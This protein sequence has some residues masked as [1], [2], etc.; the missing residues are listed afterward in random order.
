MLKEA[1]ALAPGPAERAKLRDE[2]VA[3]LALRDVGEPRAI[4]IDERER[5]EI[6]LDRLERPADKR[7]RRPAPRPALSAD[8]DTVR[9]F[10]VAKRQAQS[11][12]FRWP[13]PTSAPA[14]PPPGRPEA[15]TPK[16]GKR[17]WPR[18]PIRPPDRLGRAERRG[19]PARPPRGQPARRLDRG[20]RRGGRP[21]PLRP[22][23]RAPARDRRPGRL[24]RRRAARHRRPPARGRRP[25]AAGSAGVRHPSLGPVDPRPP[26]P[27]PPG[28]APRHPPGLGRRPRAGEGS[29]PPPMG[30]H[31]SRRR[32]D[33]RRHAWLVD[34]EI[35]IFDPRRP[36]PEQRSTRSQQ[37]TAA[38]A[39]APRGVLSPPPATGPSTSGTSPGSAAARSSR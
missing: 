12:P 20:P 27:V 15:R 34:P 28:Q 5:R 7:R 35:A 16:A 10:D 1:A 3:F 21:P 11:R 32:D 36:G 8:G 13:R 33:R 29:T 9:F 23:G 22:A 17:T 39:S 6:P 2:A 26:G 25:E 4:P 19:H 38:G 37:L 14:A 18:P 31:L 24:G 30:G